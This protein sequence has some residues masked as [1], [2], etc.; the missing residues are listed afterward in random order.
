MDQSDQGRYSEAYSHG[1]EH[2]QYT[3]TSCFKVVCNEDGY[4][5]RHYYGHSH[6]RSK[7][8]L[9]L[10]TLQSCECLQLRERLRSVPNTGDSADY[11]SAEQCHRTCYEQHDLVGRFVL[12]HRLRQFVQFEQR[13]G[14][15][16]L[17]QLHDSLPWRERL[18]HFCPTNC[19]RSLFRRVYFFCKFG[20][21]VDRQSVV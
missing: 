14:R 21:D 4:I 6:F 9:L 7:P 13:G 8:D 17:R 20:V 15:N 11:T 18:S 5:T 3:R 1:P 10:P 19:L 2:Y 16:E 12:C